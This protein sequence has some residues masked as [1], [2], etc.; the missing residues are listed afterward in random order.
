MIYLT[1]FLKLVINILHIYFTTINRINLFYILHVYLF[2]QDY[3][4]K[5][6][7]VNN[8]FAVLTGNNKAIR[9]GSGKVICS[10]PN[11]TILIYI[12]GHG[13]AGIIG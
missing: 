1:Y 10:R 9:G 12:A 13:N 11:D 3:T 6:V 4:G 2:L 8:I 7:N 5:E